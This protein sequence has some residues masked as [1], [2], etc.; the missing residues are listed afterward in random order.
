MIGDERVH[1]SGGRPFFEVALNLPHAGRI[2]RR[3]V[4]L[5]PDTGMTG[6]ADAAAARKSASE[7]LE[8]LDPCLEQDE[9]PPG[10]LGGQVR[11]RAAALGRTLVDQIEAGGFGHDRLGQCVRNLFECLE[12]GREGADI[13]LRA[14]EN[15][16]SLQRPV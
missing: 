15:P 2:A 10:A 4:L 13:S 11:E 1:G 16:R 9:N 8:L 5:M 12:M 6:G 14:G 3:I 7:L